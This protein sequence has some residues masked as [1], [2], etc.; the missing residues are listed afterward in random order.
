MSFDEVYEMLDGVRRKE[1]RK[2]PVQRGFVEVSGTDLLAA[3]GRWL[4]DFTE[5]NPVPGSRRA[6][7]FFRCW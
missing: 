7:F 2:E 6:A 4:R 3:M 1:G 5:H